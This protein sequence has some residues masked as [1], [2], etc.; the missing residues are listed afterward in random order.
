MLQILEVKN[1]D[2]VVCQLGVFALSKTLI[3]LPSPGGFDQAV[4]WYN[5]STIGVTNSPS[6]H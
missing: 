2:F 6:K 4:M 1:P 5:I 3:G